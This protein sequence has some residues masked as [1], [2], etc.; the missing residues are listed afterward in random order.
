VVV[1]N[2]T[3]IVAIVT[4]LV[5]LLGA[6]VMDADRLERFVDWLT[7][8]EVHHDS[9]GNVVVTAPTLKRNSLEGETPKADV[10]HQQK[11]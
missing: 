1:H 8:I 7:R 4:A 3:S 9:K 5:A 11:L 2:P 10:D 6:A